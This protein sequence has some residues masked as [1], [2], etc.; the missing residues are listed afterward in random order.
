MKPEPVCEATV[1]DYSS[2]H[3]PFVRS[4]GYD[5]QHAVHGI[6]E[7]AGT[8]V[9][10]LQGRQALVVTTP[11]VDRNVTQPLLAECAPRLNRSVPTLV[12]V[13]SEE[14]KTQ[15]KVQLICTAALE[16]GLDRTAV[17]VAIGGGVCMD[18]TTMAAAAI[19][20]GL[21]QIRIPTTL[22]GQVDA[23]IGVKG[24]VNFHGHKSYLGCHFPPE[25]VLVN[26]GFLAGLPE[27]HFRAGLAEIVKMGIVAD[28]PLFA[29]LESEAHLTPEH[30]AAGAGNS[31]TIV[32]R[33]IVSLLDELEP[34]LFEEQ[35]RGRIADF[36]HTFSPAIESA[37]R[38]EVLHGEA[39]AID[40]AL[41]TELAANLGLLSGSAYDRIRAVLRRLHLPTFSPLLTLE[42]CLGAMDAARRHRRGCMNLILPCAIGKGVCIADSSDIHQAALRMALDRLSREAAVP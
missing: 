39:V 42:R 40:M 32:W 31:R 27:R 30:F 1:A 12:L 17:L 35:A 5:V 15:E 8:L 3:M 19:R 33:S 4:G 22:I 26:Q 23:G 14:Q 24:A 11:T 20:R 25:L 18:L 41:S 10:T 28:A 34:N 36:G 29:L 21:S 2:R 9:R 7:V 37:S 16:A 38:F 6:P 13:C